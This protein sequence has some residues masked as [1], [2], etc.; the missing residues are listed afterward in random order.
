MI[1]EANLQQTLR[2]LG[3]SVS[4]LA[5][6]VEHLNDAVKVNAGLVRGLHERLAA[7]EATDAVEA[8]RL[9]LVA[10]EAAKDHLEPHDVCGLGKP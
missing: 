3:E 9:R 1:D 10:L 7:L 4:L 8:A 6:S 2:L 5:D